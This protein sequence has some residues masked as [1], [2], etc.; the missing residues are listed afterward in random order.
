M[1]PGLSKFIIF[2]SMK[3]RL[4]LLFFA[5]F[6][7]RVAALTGTEPDTAAADK[8]GYNLIGLNEHFGF[9][10]FSLFLSFV[11]QTYGKDTFQP[12]THTFGL[13]V[14]GDVLTGVSFI[15]LI[16]YLQYFS[17]SESFTQG[18]IARQT[19]RDA[20]LAFTSVLVSPRLTYRKARAF[21]GGG[22]SLHLNL[23]SQFDED[24][25]SKTTPSFK[26]GIGLIAGGELPLTSNVSFMLLITYRHTYDWNVLYRRMF[27]VSAGLAI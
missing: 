18:F 21:F 27:S 15:H 23:L 7:A 2:Y 10:G 16:P 19:T 6:L 25:Y 17:Y 12:N 3:N 22:P 1:T 24:N 8:G 5:L 26:N 11:K 9:N 13:G 20:G 14:S 4:C